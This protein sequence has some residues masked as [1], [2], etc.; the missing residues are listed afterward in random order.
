MTILAIVGKADKRVLAYPLIKALS[1]M[2][3]TCV[4]TD[5]VAYRRLYSG[6]ADSGIIDDVEINI[7][8]SLSEDVA[9]EME[10]DREETEFDYMLF[11]TDTFVPD[12]AGKVVALCSQ[13]RTFL[14][15]EIDGLAE[16]NDDGRFVFATMALYTKTKRFW[17]VP[18]TQI[19]WKADYV[20][21]ACETE[22]RRQL[23]PLK[24]K[25][26]DGFLCDAFAQTLNLNPMNMKKILDRK[27]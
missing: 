2:G 8:K 13:S 3:K 22:E 6:T 19:V 23:M 12:H 7:Q 16:E 24:D 26:V 11:L 25:T 5:D 27:L 17:K 10:K 9:E 15:E 1:L 21:Y 20:E 4:V 18:L 14:G